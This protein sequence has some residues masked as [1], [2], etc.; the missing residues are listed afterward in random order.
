MAADVS[1][2]HLETTGMGEIVTLPDM[3]VF[4][5]QVSE[6]RKSA[7]D[8]KTAVDKVIAAFNKRLEEEGVAR[9]DIES[10]NITLRPEYQYKKD[11]KP[12]LIGYRANRN[13][14]VTVRDLAKL[15]SYLDGALGDGINSIT[16]IKLKVSDESKF[17]EQARQAAI[18]DAK[19][20]AASL[21]KGFG[22]SVDGVWRITY[23]NSSPRPMLMRSMEMDSSAN[24]ES[25][26]QDAKIII[27]DEVDVVFRLE[28]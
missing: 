23:R 17:I 5:V 18:L 9:I 15:N 1:F 24:I 13:V 20:K 22:E 4:S 6:I 16:N 27:R 12:E 10:T 7:K 8:A 26:Y 3:A 28:D 11:S 2:P 19:E 21:A 14:N 25:T